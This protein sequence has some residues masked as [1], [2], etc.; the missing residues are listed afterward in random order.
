M[1]PLGT[2]GEQKNE[3]W[4]CDILKWD[5]LIAENKM[6]LGVHFKKAFKKNK[7]VQVFDDAKKGK[8]K[9]AKPSKPPEDKELEKDWE[10]DETDKE[11]EVE[12]PPEASP[13]ASPDKEQGGQGGPVGEEEAKGGEKADGEASDSIL[14]G[15]PAGEALP[16]GEADGHELGAEETKEPELAH[17]A[18]NPLHEAQ[19]DEGK[20]A[21]SEP[22]AK[23]KKAGGGVCF[24]SKAKKKKSEKKAAKAEVEDEGEDEPLLDKEAKEKAEDEKEASGAVK[25]VRGLLGL[26]GDDPPNSYWL[27]MD[28]PN[29]EEGQP[30]IPM[31]KLCLSIELIPKADAE[32]NDNGFGR[33]DP[34]HSPKLPP[35]TGRLSFSW[36]PF[37]M[38]AQLCGPKICFYFTCCILGSLMI[39]L[40]IFC[41]PVMNIIISITLKLLLG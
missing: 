32:Q 28:I 2:A 37:A 26:G 16:A 18:T 7:T 17:E 35:P 24:G 23:Q 33:N 39:V 38:G 14:G 22:M 27:H 6:D 34:N 1:V 10:F 13:E 12:P 25:V 40:M 30:R 19:G 15:E 4:D 20:G 31:G 36:N 29:P 21:K 3:K 41:Q 9:K 5:D 11:A 8:A